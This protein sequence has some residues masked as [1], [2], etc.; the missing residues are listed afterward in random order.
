MMKWE[1]VTKNCDFVSCV[2]LTKDWPKKGNKMGMYG[3]P[4]FSCF[5]SRTIRKVL[6]E[7]DDAFAALEAKADLVI[8]KPSKNK[9]STK[10][11]KLPQS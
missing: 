6:S 3:E 7:L 11:S 10:L 5:K 9:K 4:K 1:G 2:Y 8:E